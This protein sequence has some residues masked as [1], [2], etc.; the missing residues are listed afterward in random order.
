MRIEIDLTVREAIA[1][2]SAVLVASYWASDTNEKDT[3]ISI[4]NKCKKVLDSV[5]LSA[6]GKEFTS[7]LEEKK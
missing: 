5:I 1:L 7:H 3:F 4:T 6:E 2:H